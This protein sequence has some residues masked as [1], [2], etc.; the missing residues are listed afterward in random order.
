MKMKKEC[1]IF[2]FIL[3][4][5]TI[6][7]T[8]ITQQWNIKKATHLNINEIFNHFE[9]PWPRRFSKDFI[10]QMLKRYNVWIYVSLDAQGIEEKIL[11]VCVERYEKTN[12]W[13]HIAWLLANPKGLGTGGKLLDHLDKL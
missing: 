1:I 6:V 8:D 12:K 7:C 4:P 10:T 9:I 3:L 11:G 5:L 13:I 2:I